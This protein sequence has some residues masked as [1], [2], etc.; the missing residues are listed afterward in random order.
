MPKISGVGEIVFGIEPT[1]G[2][3]V[4]MFI[5]TKPATSRRAETISATEAE[6]AG[7]TKIIF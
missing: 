5:G 7:I 3:I 4:E 1:I 2:E 6:V